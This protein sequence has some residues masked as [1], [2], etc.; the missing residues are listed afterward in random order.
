MGGGDDDDPDH[1]EV[2]DPAQTFV[3]SRER[4]SDGL[5]SSLRRSQDALR[6]AR[7]TRRAVFG[8]DVVDDEGPP[9]PTDPV[10]RAAEVLRRAAAVRREAQAG[11]R[12]ALER[13]ARA[14]EELERLKEIPPAPDA[15][16]ADAG[17]PA[18]LTTT[19]RRREL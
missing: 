8:A 12:A 11:G 4:V 5:A 9:L 14:R 1:D 10:A 19:P 17:Q 6:T 18:P 3:G 15:V 2:P 16:E 13:E 7:E